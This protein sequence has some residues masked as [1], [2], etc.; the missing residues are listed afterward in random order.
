MQLLPPPSIKRRLRAFM[1][2]VSFIAI[3]FFSLAIFLYQRTWQSQEMV[4]RF[5]DLAGVVGLNSVAALTFK[6]PQAAVTTLKALGGEDEFISAT[7]FNQEGKLFAHYAKPGKNSGLEGATASPEADVG[8]TIIIPLVEGSRFTPNRLIVWK[9]VTLEGETIGVVFLEA[10][11]HQLKAS[12][13]GGIKITLLTMI[14]ALCCTYPV[15]LLFQKT[16]A[17]PILNLAQTMTAISQQQDYTVRTVKERDD[18]LGDLIDCFNNMLAQIER[19][20]EE[21]AEHREHLEEEVAR[22][23]AELSRMN[24]ELEQAVQEIQESEQHLTALMEKLRAGVIVVDADSHRLAYINPYAA[25]VLG[26]SQ[27]QLKGSSCRQFFCSERQGYCG[28][29]GESSYPDGEEDC[30]ISATG[31]SVPVLKSVVPIQRKGRPYLIET[32]FD[33]TELKKAAEELRQSKEVAEAASHAK[34]QFL[35]NMS[36]EIRTPMN[37]ILGMTELLLTTSLSETQRRFI[38]TVRNSALTLLNLLGDILDF[39]KIEAGRLELERLDFDLPLAVEEV[40]EMFAEAAHAKGLEYFCV[41]SPEVPRVVQ[42]D[43]LR[44]RQILMNLLSNAIK[45]T[46]QGEVLTQ[47]SVLRDTGEMVVIL[48]EVRDTGLGVK[49]EAQELIF[50][51][52]YQADGSTTRK[53]GGSGLG[54]AIAKR[55]VNLMAGDIGVA[56]QPGQGSRFWFTVGLPRVACQGEKLP[57][58][59]SPLKGLKVLVVDDNPTYRLLLNQQLAYW[60]M[61]GQTAGDGMEALASLQSAATQG[62]PFQLAIIDR[63][64][65]KIDGPGLVQAIR[66]DPGLSSMLLLMLTSSDISGSSQETETLAI[67]ASLRKPVRISH[68]YN[69]ILALEGRFPKPRGPATLQALT[70]PAAVKYEAAVLV[71]EDNPI[72]QDVI[73]ALLKYLGCRADIVS[74]GRQALEAAARKPYDLVFMDCQM[75]DMDGYEATAALRKQEQQSDPAA[76]TIIVALTAH[77]LEGDRQKCLD[78]GMDDY[79][80]KPFTL[81]Q[82]QHILEAWLGKKKRSFP[83]CQAASNLLPGET[84]AKPALAGEENS[85]AHA[86][87]LVLDPKILQTLRLLESSGTPGLLSRLVG[88]YCDD[89]E[90][91]LKDLQN[92]AVEG[93]GEAL[94]SMAHRFKSSSANLGAKG[95]A[96]LLKKLEMLAKEHSLEEAKKILPEIFQEHSRVLAALQRELPETEA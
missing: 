43:P 72:N 95:L 3:T 52:F 26:A 64:V 80:G 44:L 83:G 69:A 6:D 22:R 9:P 24:R 23:T 20:D 8:K 13:W 47:V 34:S 50:N 60:G 91:L 92:A 58:H 71:A 68:L 78:A 12:L 66:S 70:A 61:D 96:D 65:A 33:L 46:G 14:F 73:M 74:S 16:L 18:E 1:M 88:N 82:L 55:L 77:A 79:L 42:G 89:S 21:L 81:G 37:G 85:E 2:L 31:E 93:N 86:P 75:P 94:I 4:R 63:N 27:E 38:V 19:R 25:D 67:D 11:L 56:S 30:L 84:V 32:F 53:F 87:Q 57:D 39:S 28:I 29:A 41:I 10:G 15:S 54:L 90:G 62:S 59:C 51:D 35:A 5:S 76:H 40:V 48:F 7:L 36:H 49:P 17:R 45:F